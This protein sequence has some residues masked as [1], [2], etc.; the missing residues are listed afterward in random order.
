MYKRQDAVQS[1]VA[2]NEIL[3]VPPSCDSTGFRF[4]ELG[5]VISGEGSGG[6]GSV[7]YTHLDVYKRQILYTTLHLRLLTLMI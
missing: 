1:A 3:T 4:S 2:V 5:I 7:S 6:V